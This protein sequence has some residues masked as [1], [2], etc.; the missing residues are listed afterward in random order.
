[1]TC[2]FG[3]FRDTGRAQNQ[4]ASA[5]CVP[6]PRVGFDRPS[7]QIHV[8]AML[9]D[10]SLEDAPKAQAGEVSKEIAIGDLNEQIRARESERSR[11]VYDGTNFGVGVSDK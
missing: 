4:M 9:V 3:K 7:P 5:F 2:P 1:M 10:L 11:P 6:L 8:K